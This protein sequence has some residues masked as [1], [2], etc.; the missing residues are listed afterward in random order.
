MDFV[1]FTVRL[2][3][4]C[5]EDDLKRLQS[6]NPKLKILGVYRA[7]RRGRA[8]WERGRSG[9][10]TTGTGFSISAGAGAGAGGKYWGACLLS[11]WSAWTPDRGSGCNLVSRRSSRWPRD[12]LGIR[13]ICVAR[14]RTDLSPRPVVCTRLGS[15]RPQ[16]RTQKFIEFTQKDLEERDRKLRQVGGWLCVRR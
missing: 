16:I 14:A 4:R 3:G 6:L 12:P 2:L 15:W 7:V 10:T 5:R 13:W 9:W 11:V 1:E 8:P